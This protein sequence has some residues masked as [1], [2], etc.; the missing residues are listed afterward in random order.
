MPPKPPASAR[1]SPEALGPLRL[2][3]RLHKTPVYLVGGAPRDLLLG[4]PVSD[5]DLACKGAQALAKKLAGALKGAFVPMDEANGVYRIA[6][7]ASSGALRQVDV[8]LQS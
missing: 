6:L 5:L 7:P 4:R 1:L 3:A 8:V 2:A